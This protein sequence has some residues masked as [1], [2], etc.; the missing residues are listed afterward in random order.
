MAVLL[1]LLL[2]TQS[3]HSENPF[4]FYLFENV[5]G[6]SKLFSQEIQLLQELREYKV[7]LEDL[8]ENMASVKF[9]QPKDLLNPIGNITEMAHLEQFLSNLIRLDRFSS[10]FFAIF[11]QNYSP[12]FGHYNWNYCLVHF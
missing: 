9:H 3:V 7:V 10:V 6:T 11:V 4:S 8:H 5:E 12:D 2:F 1:F